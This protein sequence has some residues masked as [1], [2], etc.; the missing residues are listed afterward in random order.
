MPQKVVF[1]VDDV[2]TDNTSNPGYTGVIIRKT[3]VGEVTNL[4]VDVESDEDDKDIRISVQ[5]TENREWV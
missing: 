5:T 4:S 2:V 1:E 3:E